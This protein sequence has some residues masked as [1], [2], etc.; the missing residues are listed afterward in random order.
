MLGDYGIEY[1][2]ETENMTFKISRY[3]NGRTPL[4]IITGKTP[5]VS[6]YLDFGLYDWVT[7]RNNARDLFHPKTDLFSTR[8]LI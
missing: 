1:V 5:D 3:Y 7:Y 2:C 6:E 4:G 8:A